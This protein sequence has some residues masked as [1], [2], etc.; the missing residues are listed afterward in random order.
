MFRRHVVSMQ[1]GYKWFHLIRAPGCCGPLIDPWARTTLASQTDLTK[2][3]GITADEIEDLRRDEAYQALVS[4]PYEGNLSLKNLQRIAAVDFV[5][6]DLYA[7]YP[8][9]GEEAMFDAASFQGPG[10]LLRDVRRAMYVTTGWCTP[11]STS[12]TK[13]RT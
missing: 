10:T 12:R 9:D 6:A 4:A 5:V 2:W 8:A 11:I 3:T 1:T 7:Q 13:P